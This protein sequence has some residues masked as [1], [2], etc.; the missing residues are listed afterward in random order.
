MQRALLNRGPAALAVL[1]G[2]LAAGCSNIGGQVA[3][4]CAYS[5]IVVESEVPVAD[6]TT[7]GPGC[8]GAG[9]PY[10]S[11]PADGAGCLSFSVQLTGTGACNL[12]G[13]AVDGRTSATQVNVGVG[14]AGGCCGPG[15]VADGRPSLIFRPPPSDSF[16]R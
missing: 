3:C 1:L 16:M 4:D 2:A 8:S 12:V 7:G 13:T 10:C 11:V 5:T 14:S 9:P 15:Y 6:L